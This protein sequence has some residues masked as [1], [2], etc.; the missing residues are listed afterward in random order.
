MSK[1]ESSREQGTVA[2]RWSS[3]LFGN[4]WFLLCLAPLLW[5]GNAVAGK[6]AV[7]EWQPFTLTGV[8]WLCAALILTPFAWGP[9]Q[10]DWPLIRK[11]LKLLIALGAIGMCLFNLLMY[12]ALGYTSAINVSIVQAAIPVL[13]MMANFIVLSQRVRLLQ[14]IGVLCSIAGVLVTT[15]AGNPLAVIES[16]FNVGDALMLLACVFYAGYTF[17]LRWRPGI[18]WLS[19]MWV[20]SLSAFAMTLPFVAWEWSSALP[21]L[22]SINGLLI[23]AYVVVAPTI[24]SQISWA[25]GVELIGANRAGLFVNLVPVFGALLAVLLLGESFEWYHALGLS[26]VLGGIGVA[27]RAATRPG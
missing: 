19:F 26:L 23:L 2:H 24:V 6:L 1:P 21:E 27:E 22:P 5:G 20:I 9:L 14:I 4:A 11:H 25:R 10:R 3:L 13:I 12:F 16:G 17:G 8:R 7:A 15:T 18:H